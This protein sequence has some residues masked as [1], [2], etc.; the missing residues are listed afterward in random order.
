[1]CKYMKMYVRIY[2][3]L[4]LGLFVDSEGQLTNE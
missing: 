3:K 2:D 4:S 1:M